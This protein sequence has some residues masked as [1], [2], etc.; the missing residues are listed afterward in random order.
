MQYN[1]RSWIKTT[2]SNSYLHGLV[3]IKNLMSVEQGRYVDVFA[4]FWHP[5]KVR[6]MINKVPL[7]QIIC[8][9]F[10]AVEGQGTI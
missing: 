6:V 9:L 1:N 2:A 3:L 10:K 4:Q 7:I 8:A 5:G